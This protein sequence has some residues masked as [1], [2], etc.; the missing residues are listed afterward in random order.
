ML[1]CEKTVSCLSPSPSAAALE[2]EKERERPEV[3]RR[4]EVKIWIKIDT[5]GW[6]G[7]KCFLKTAPVL[8]SEPPTVLP[9]TDIQPAAALEVG[10]RLYKH[11]SF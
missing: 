4:N 11:P 7:L 6:S 3:R 8:G 10:Y 2:G 9:P 1:L 5:D